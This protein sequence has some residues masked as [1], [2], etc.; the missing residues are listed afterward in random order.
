MKTK[1]G[2]GQPRKS[3]H[4]KAVSINTT[5]P[6]EVAKRLKRLGNG[7]ASRGLRTVA[8][9]WNDRNAKLVGFAR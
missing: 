1:R 2:P 6:P 8:V 9:D 4:L 7:S 3:A 5:V